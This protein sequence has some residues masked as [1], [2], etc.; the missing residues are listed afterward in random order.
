M[1][2]KKKSK[3]GWPPWQYSLRNIIKDLQENGGQSLYLAQAILLTHPPPSWSH[4]RQLSSA[5]ILPSLSSQ[6]RFCGPGLLNC[7]LC[8]NCCKYD[9]LWIPV[10]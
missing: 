7:S 3:Y 1:F 6:T 4:I 9:H 2:L 5:H 8:S 10:G